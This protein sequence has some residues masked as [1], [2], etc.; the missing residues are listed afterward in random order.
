[1]EDMTNR[2]Y[3]Q[4]CGLAYA[5]DVVGERWT[6]LIVRELIPG[7]R[8]FKDLLDGLP[9]ISTNLLAERL[10]SLAEQGILSQRTLP[11]PAGSTVYELTPL[12]RS[13]EPM[14]LELGKWGSQFVP[15]SWEDAILLRLGSYALTFKTFFRPQAAQGID[16]TY[17]LHIGNEVLQ[18]QVKDGELAV[19]QGQALKS[20]VVIYT[21]MPTFML[22]MPGQLEPRTAIAQ[23]RVCIEGDPTALDRLLQMCGLPGGHTPA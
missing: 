4:Y 9:G 13:L 21:D 17:E 16:E 15:P 22:L 7:P 10:K 5:L 19:Q 23:G 8:R 3:H 14:L 2:S 11:P 20:D 1:M 12:G 18:V 6:L